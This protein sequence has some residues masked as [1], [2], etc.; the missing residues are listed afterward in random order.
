V[1]NVREGDHFDEPD[2]VE[3]IIL[4]WILECGI[5]HGLDYSAQDSDWWR[6]LVNAVMNLLISLSAGNFLTG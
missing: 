1:K 5:R 6:A 3:S 2:V 4:K